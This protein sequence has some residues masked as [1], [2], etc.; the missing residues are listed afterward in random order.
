MKTLKSSATSEYIRLIKQFP[1]APIKNTKHLKE[2]YKVI[3]HLF[4]RR[5]AGNL[6]QEEEEYF[7]VLTSLVISY[8]KIHYPI[9]KLS[10][11]ETLRDLM[12]INNLK[13]ADLAHLFSSKSNLSEILSGHRR[14]SKAQARRLSDYFKMSIDAFID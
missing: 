8:E 1:L 6:T 2:A 14:I 13:Q 4:D 9:K 12:E 3:E 5:R 7:D 11:L 10:P